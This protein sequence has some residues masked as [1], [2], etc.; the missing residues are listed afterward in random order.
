MKSPTGSKYLLIKQLKK[1]IRE[2]IPRLETPE[3]ADELTDHIEALRKKG[4]LS[5]VEAQEMFDAIIE[6]RSLHGWSE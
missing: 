3:Q 4:A 6:V 5:N 2:A 1:V